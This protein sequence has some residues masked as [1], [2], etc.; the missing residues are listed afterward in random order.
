MQNKNE[1]I[2][3]LIIIMKNVFS[4]HL[5]RDEETPHIHIDFV[6]FIRNSKRGLD[7]R[8]FLKRVLKR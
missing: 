4:D 6:H 8:V 3:R 7:T 2:E 5:H 1:V